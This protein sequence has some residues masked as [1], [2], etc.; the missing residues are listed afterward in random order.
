MHPLVALF[1]DNTLTT[2][3]LVSTLVGSFIGAITSFIVNAA[4]IEISL[5]SFFS[6][7]STYLIPHLTALKYYGFFF[8]VAGSLTTYKISLNF[9]SPASLDEF[10]AKKYLL[11]GFGFLV[12]LILV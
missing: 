4:L 5:N 2:E 8:I 11:M 6:L 9:K 3:T 12:K 7:V 1:D 10:Q